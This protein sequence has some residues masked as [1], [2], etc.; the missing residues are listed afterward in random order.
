VGH[1]KSSSEEK[2][3]PVPDDTRSLFGDVSD[4]AGFATDMFRLA[5]DASPFGMMLI[6]S[7]GSIIAV[8]HE[9]ERIFG[10][11][12]EDLVGRFADLLAPRRL[13]GKR[14]LQHAPAPQDASAR[15]IGARGDL[16]G[17]RSD[18]SEFLL[19][20]SVTPIL[21]RNGTF[22]LAVIADASERRRLE[23]LKHDFVSTA[24]H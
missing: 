4:H 5:F 11:V 8:N 19:E 9:V 17:L 7:E 12:A 14:M 10:Y 15:Q 21:A 18:G 20:A 13:R 24:S 16:F 22:T 2:G 23:Q 1:R 6:A 3:L